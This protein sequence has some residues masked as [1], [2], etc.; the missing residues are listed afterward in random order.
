VRVSTQQAP[1]ARNALSCESGTD[2]MTAT[3]VVLTLLQQ[4]S[5][6]A[7]PVMAV[8]CTSHKEKSMKL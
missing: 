7:V 8:V 1:L 3:A 4:R 6:A 2:V 5:V